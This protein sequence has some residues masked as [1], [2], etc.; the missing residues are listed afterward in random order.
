MSLEN[1]RSQGA[2]KSRLARVGERLLDHQYK[3]FAT[4]AGILVNTFVDFAATKSLQE[5]ALYIG[6]MAAVGALGDIAAR[7]DSR[8]LKPAPK[9][10]G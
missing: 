7:G 6:L 10:L 8:D 3:A 4:L 2:D 1:G 5:Q 9:V